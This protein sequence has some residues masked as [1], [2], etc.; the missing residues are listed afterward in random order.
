MSPTRC[1]SAS[2]PGGT[3]PCV[4]KGLPKSPREHSDWARCF[5]VC[6]A[7]R[8][9]VLSQEAKDDDWQVCRD[10][11]LNLEVDSKVKPRLRWRYGERPDDRESRDAGRRQCRH[12]S[13]LRTTRAAAE[14]SKNAH[15]IS[16]VSALDRQSAGAGAERQA[17]WFLV[18]RDRLVSARPRHGWGA[19]P[20]RPS[21]RRTAARD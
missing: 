21:G 19:M 15:R 8:H 16:R 2:T 11:M 18:E 20:L 10:T 14:G 6:H 7:R 17:L 13:V 12:D 5:F 1:R 9:R 3:S 4:A